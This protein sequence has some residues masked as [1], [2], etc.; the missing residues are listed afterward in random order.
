MYGKLYRCPFSANAE[1]LS[2]I[3][4]DEGNS[5]S[6]E[7]PLEDIEHYTNEL[8]YIP[9]C[10]YCNGRAHDAPEIEPAIQSKI[11]LDYKMYSEPGET[12]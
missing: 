12:S 8:K 2:G 6:V 3:P 1:R 5:V 10:N 11:K 7:A 9:A 4:K